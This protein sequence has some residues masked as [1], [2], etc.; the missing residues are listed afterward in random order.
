MKILTLNL[1]K[2]YFNEI[3]SGIK[4]EEYREV[5]DYWTKRLK[6]KYDI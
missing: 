3:K 1:N 2:E 4:K 6:Q 5:K